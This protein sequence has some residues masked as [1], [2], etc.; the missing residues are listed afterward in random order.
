MIRRAEIKHYFGIHLQMVVCL[1]SSS[2]L[3]VN[4]M[5]NADLDAIFMICVILL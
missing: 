5:T 3:R 2:F 1:L 4:V